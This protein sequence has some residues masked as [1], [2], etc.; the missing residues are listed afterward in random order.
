MTDIDVHRF[1][2]QDGLELAYREIGEGRP[3]V[4]LHGFSATGLQWLRHG[5][6]IALAQQGYRVILPDFRGHGGS[7]RSHNPTAYPPD[8]LADDGFALID[9]LGLKNYDLGG[10]SLGGRIVLRMLI[11]GAK[12]AHALV[13]GQGLSALNCATRTG[14]YYRVL[15]ALVRGDKVEPGTPDGEAAYWFRQLAGDPRALLCVLDSLVGTP[16][17]SLDE[18]KT[19]M[20][21]TVG[22]QDHDH[23][24]AKELASAVPRSRF[25]QVPGDHWNALDSP[26]L[27]SALVGFL[28]NISLAQA[29]SSEQH[30]NFST[31]TAG[32]ALHRGPPAH[33]KFRTMASSGSV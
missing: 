15:T 8:I 30:E 13:G 16:T 21:V 18:I 10:Y 32:L 4:L 3:L 27:E 26:Q 23:A 33:G 5:P 12:P 28:A 22:D 31:T 11:R 17:V 9:H 1:A 20:L 25:I 19:Q 2:G 24:S 29:A 7:G 6:A 14:R